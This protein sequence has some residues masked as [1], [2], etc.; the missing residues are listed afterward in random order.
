VLTDVVMPTRDGLYM[1][2][3]RGASEEVR[4]VSLH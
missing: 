3:R 2:E 4:S 1:V